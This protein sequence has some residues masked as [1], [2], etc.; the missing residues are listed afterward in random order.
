VTQL[1]GEHRVLVDVHTGA[2]ESL[3]VDIVQP[4]SSRATR[5]ALRSLSLSLSPSLVVVVIVVVVVVIV[6]VVVVVVSIPRLPVLIA[7][8][9]EVLPCSITSA[10]R[11]TEIWTKLSSR[12]IM[13]MTN[14]TEYDSGYAAVSTVPFG[15]DAGHPHDVARMQ[16]KRRQ[17]AMNC[18]G[19]GLH[20]GCVA[21]LA[22]RRS[23]VSGRRTDAVLRSACSRR[24]TTM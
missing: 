17:Q 14:L 11:R 12:G 23:P 10:I 5:S 4:T 8:H 16:C 3:R 19:S 20:V 22:E 13:M 2:S 21:Q 1:D 24:V 7:S 6:V 18:N 15:C 9:F